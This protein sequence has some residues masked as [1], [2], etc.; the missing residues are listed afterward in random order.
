MPA[1][2]MYFRTTVLDL[3]LPRLCTGERLTA[4]EISALGHGGL[5]RSC[6]ECRYPRCSFGLAGAVSHD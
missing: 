5:C 1:C 3:I 6:P 2:G 4:R